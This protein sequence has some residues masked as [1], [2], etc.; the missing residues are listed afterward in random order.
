MQLCRPLCICSSACSSR[1]RRLRFTLEPD[2]YADVSARAPPTLHAQ[3]TPHAISRADRAAS[4]APQNAQLRA[5]AGHEHSEAD[6][7]VICP[8]LMRDNAAPGVH[9]WWAY[10]GWPVA[11]RARHSRHALHQRRPFVPQVL[12]CERGSALCAQP[13]MWADFVSRLL[14]QRACDVQGTPLS[15]RRLIVIEYNGVNH[16]SATVYS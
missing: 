1:R 16:Y 11:P 6:I 5:L 3:P 9:T 2:V 14:A 10:C 12:F 15:V 8:L 13:C 7:V 4:S